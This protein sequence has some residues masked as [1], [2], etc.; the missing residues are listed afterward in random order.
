MQSV[1]E[2]WPVFAILQKKIFVKKLCKNLAWKLGPGSFSS[3][4]NTL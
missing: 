4:K 3:L 1:N 2:I